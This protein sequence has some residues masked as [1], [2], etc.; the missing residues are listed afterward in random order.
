MT[1]S[2]V[3]SKPEKFSEAPGSSMPESV[4]CPAF[5][6]YQA[7]FP[8]R[9]KTLRHAQGLS[10]AQLAEKVGIT[11]HSVSH[12]ERGLSKPTM[13][14]L[15]LLGEVLHVSTEYLIH[16]D[17]PLNLQQE[18][19]TDSGR[20]RNRLNTYQ[21]NLSSELKAAEKP[22]EMRDVPQQKE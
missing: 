2:R 22:E 6:N 4:S 11:F 13:K 9:L 12:Y 8:V 16:G 10:Q 7:D 18:E 3:T 1:K 14:H 5:Q 15:L 20:R 21:E 17:S 19:T